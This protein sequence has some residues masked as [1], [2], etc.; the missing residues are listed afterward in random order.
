MFI[1]TCGKTDSRSRKLGA[2][3][4]II[5]W[6]ANSILRTESCNPL[7]IIG[8]YFKYVVSQAF[9]P[10]LYTDHADTCGTGRTPYFPALY[11]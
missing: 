1:N 2:I 8:N 7:I 5:S 4:I 3:V 11:D 10:V 6:L 9:T